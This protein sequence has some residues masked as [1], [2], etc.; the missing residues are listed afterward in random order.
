M[1]FIS[2]V[3][4]D[5]LSRAFSHI[6][7]ETSNKMSESQVSER[8]KFTL[9][10]FLP[11]KKATYDI[12]FSIISKQ[13]HFDWKLFFLIV[14]ILFVPSIF[15]CDFLSTS[16]IFFW[17]LTKDKMTITYREQNYKEQKTDK[18]VQAVITMST[19]IALFFFHF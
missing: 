2:N 17:T 3:D 9:R 10:Y 15:F 16:T 8:K 14:R 11:Q 12:K 19:C 7:S 1:S 4:F 6:S 18:L 13:D 5:H